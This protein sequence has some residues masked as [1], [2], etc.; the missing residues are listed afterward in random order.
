MKKSKAMSNSSKFDHNISIGGLSYT[1][2]GNGGGTGRINSVKS[3]VRE[4]HQ[5]YATNN[6]SPRNLPDI[7]L[8]M[9]THVRKNS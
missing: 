4:Q 2:S 1:T 7:K 3:K 8:D 5:G 9:V 6:N